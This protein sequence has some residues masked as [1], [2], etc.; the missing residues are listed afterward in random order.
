MSLIANNIAASLQPQILQYISTKIPPPPVSTVRG[1]VVRHPLFLM[2]GFSRPAGGRGG[3]SLHKGS[4]TP[5]GLEIS[6]TY[7]LSI[8]KPAKPVL[9]LSKSN[10]SKSKLKWARSK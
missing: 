2:R 9:H 1:T 4:T 3:S 6:K 8:S 5:P 7:A 10:I